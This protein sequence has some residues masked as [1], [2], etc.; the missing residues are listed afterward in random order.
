MG[1]VKAS[2]PGK[3]LA[4]CWLISR[5]LAVPLPLRTRGRYIVDAYDERVRLRC[6]NWSGADQQDGVPGGLQHQRANAIARWIAEDGGFNCVRIPW[7]VWMVQTNPI[8]SS[9]TLL[10]ANPELQGLTTLEILDAVIDA[11]SKH[12]LLVILDNHMSDGDWCCSNTDGNGLW[13]NERW[14]TSSWLQAHSIVAA[15]Y[16]NTDAV[17][18]AELRNELRVATINGI[19]ISP[20]WCTEVESSDWRSAAISA[21][22]AVHSHAPHWLLVVDGLDYS[23]NF[24]GV[25]DCPIPLPNLVYSA[26]DYAWTQPPE[27]Y[28]ELANLL[29]IKWG[30]LF[31]SE[32]AVYQ[33]PVWVSEFGTYHDGREMIL[34]SWW[35]H[36]VRYVNENDLDWA[37]WRVDGTESR[38]QTRTFGAEALFGILN[39]TWNGPARDGILLESLQALTPSKQAG[40]RTGRSPAV[41]G[42]D[43]SNLSQSVLVV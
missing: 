8:V 31:K 24:D 37:Y 18:G 16:A 15:R 17:V 32:G 5:T 34:G 41:G 1:A 26:H 38:G 10:A 25:P 13:Y 35:Q 9:D 29:D 23:T 43:P 21:G 3:V 36:F 2:I 22:L 39:T 30:Y 28:E 12:D 40:G 14:P 27:S 7:S 20:T 6:V 19:A 11:C 4:A 33:A 42:V